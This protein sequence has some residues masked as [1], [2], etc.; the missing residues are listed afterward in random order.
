MQIPI[1]PMTRHHWHMSDFAEGLSRKAKRSSDMLRTGVRV[2]KSVAR[3]R[4][5]EAS[6]PKSFAPRPTDRFTAAVYFSGDLAS[7]YQVEQWLWPFEQLAADLVESGFGDEPFGLIARNAQVA[8]HL[9]SQTHL[10]VRF[11]R[12]SSGFD[13]FMSMTSLRVVFYVNQAT[14]NF[15]SLRFPNPAHVHLSHGESE[16]ISMI[17]N[18]LKAYDYVFT[19]GRAAQTRIE[20]SLIGMESSRMLDVGRPQL[21]R[22]LSIPQEWQDFRARTPEGSTVFYAPTWEGDSPS[23][24]YGTLADNGRTLATAL[25]NA[26]YRVIFRPHPRTGILRNEFKAELE[27]VRRI[28]RDHPRGFL[29]VTADVSWQFAAAD[30][31]VAEMSSVAFDW[32]ATRKPLVM[33]APYSPDAEILPGGLLDRCPS[34]E[35]GSEAAIG[36]LLRAAGRG[37]QAGHYDDLS[38]EY[39]GDTERG[40]QLSRFIAASRKVIARRTEEISARREV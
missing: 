27:E 21:D 35:P 20:H 10:P 38:F 6:L 32:L 12:L 16:K 36:D 11:S 37:E 33:I 14:G 26:G 18:Q 28:I 30:L 5:A 1:G 23:M 31:A 24:S 2:G 9:R 8:R 29:D 7:V 13:A 19:A 15:Q 34:L 17:S 40:Q 39:L 3:G 4:L 22:P 25:L